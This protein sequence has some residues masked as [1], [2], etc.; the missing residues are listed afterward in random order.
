MH[1]ISNKVTKTIGRVFFTDFDKI[2]NKERQMQEKM[3]DPQLLDLIVK[4]VQKD[5]VVGEKEVIKALILKICLRLVKGATPTSSNILVSDI[6]GAGKDFIVKK[7]CE[8]M[9]ESEETYFHRTDLSDKVLNYWQ[10]LDEDKNP[11]SWNGKVLW[12]EDPGEDV[13]KCQGFKIRASGGNAITVLKDQV[14]HTV[15]VNGKP[16]FIITSMKTRID[17]EGVRRWDS[18]RLNN[19]S[20]HV[21][22]IEKYMLRKATGSI[23]Y[24]PDTE[25]RQGLKHLHRYGVVIPYAEELSND[26]GANETKT[27]VLKLLDYIKASCV[28]HQQQ[29]VKNEAGQLIAVYE[30]YENAMFLWNVLNKNFQTNLN[31]RQEKILLYLNSQNK[32]VT[33]REIVHNNEGLTKYFIEKEMEELAE[34]ELISYTYDFDAYANREILHLSLTKKGKSRGFTPKSYKDLKK[35]NRLANKNIVGQQIVPTD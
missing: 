22:K 23:P 17:I 19:K 28:L 1:E 8:V 33:L 15:L 27:M 25:L 10:P 2:M 20:S 30:D 29:R 18:L 34:R 16:V 24:N 31:V 11:K 32:P 12:L 35:A 6:S 7:V 21:K 26:N 3:K 5:G 13:I 9:L 4:E 14:P